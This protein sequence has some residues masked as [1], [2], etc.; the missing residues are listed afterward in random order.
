LIEFIH[1]KNFKKFD[2]KESVSKGI[3]KIAKG[4]ERFEV[5]DVVDEFIERVYSP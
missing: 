3:K 4:E 1:L 5:W 2:I